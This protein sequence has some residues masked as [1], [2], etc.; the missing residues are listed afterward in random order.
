MAQ[1]AKKTKRYLF[2]PFVLYDLAYLTKFTKPK[3]I[4]DCRSRESNILN[5]ISHQ[6]APFIHDG[7]LGKTTIEQLRKPPPLLGPRPFTTFALFAA[8][9]IELPSAPEK[10]FAEKPVSYRRDKWSIADRPKGSMTDRV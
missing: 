2:A 7:H 1:I 8:P 3:S 9:N 4:T 6:P 10:F 5:N